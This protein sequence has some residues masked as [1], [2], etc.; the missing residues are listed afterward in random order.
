MILIPTPRLS[1]NPEPD[2]QNNRAPTVGANEY[3][4]ECHR[5]SHH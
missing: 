4:P 3:D 1:S 2:P 5:L